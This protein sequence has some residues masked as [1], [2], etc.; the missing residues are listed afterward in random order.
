MCVSETQFKFHFIA[1]Y[2]KLYYFAD[3]VYTLGGV[4]GFIEIF[5]MTKKHSD[6]FIRKSR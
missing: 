3:L 1:S 5:F 4:I 2:D 6:I